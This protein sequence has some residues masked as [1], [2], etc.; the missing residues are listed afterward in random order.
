MRAAD[1]ILGG[2]GLA[3]RALVA[4]AA[5]GIAHGL[6]RVAHGLERVGAAAHVRV[7]VAHAAAVGAADLVLG[8]G[9]LDAEHGVRVGIARR[10]GHRW[11]LAGTGRAAPRITSVG[12]RAWTTPERA[13]TPG[14]TARQRARPP[15]PRA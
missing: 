6:E 15:A 2:R 5:L 12:E 3:E 9:R 10:D 4:G 7:R 14:G 13:S 11:L 8:R 1:G